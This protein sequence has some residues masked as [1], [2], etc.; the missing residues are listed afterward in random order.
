VTQNIQRSSR[1]RRNAMSAAFVLSSLCVT[2][3]V[4]CEPP[5][6][7]LFDENAIRAA[8]RVLVLPLADAPSREAV[9]SGTAFRGIIEQSILNDCN[10]DVI[11]LSKIK[12]ADITKKN[13][14]NIIDAYDPDV[15][16]EIARE[17]KADT[18]VTGQL[19]HYTIQREMSSTTITF[20]TG[21][22]TNVTHWV[23]VSLRLVEASSGKIIYTG[24]GTAQDPEGFTNAASQAVKQALASLAYFLANEK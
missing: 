3:L 19:L 10:L 1:P 14:L 6:P 15:A 11:N 12:L 4:G 20:I 2:C 18:A 7:K 5:R 17:F 13:G 21:G 9:G 22:G 23:S 8:K 24:T 16:A